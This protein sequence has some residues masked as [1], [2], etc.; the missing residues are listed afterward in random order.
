MRESVSLSYSLRLTC[1]FL[2][3]YQE[4]VVRSLD[5]RIATVLPVRGL[6]GS[7]ISVSHGGRL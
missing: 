7:S 5:G 3:R 6:M 2:V 4:L 1:P